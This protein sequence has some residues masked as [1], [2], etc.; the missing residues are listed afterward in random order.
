MGLTLSCERRPVFYFIGDSITEHGS[1]SS[2]SGFITILQNHYV[3]SVDCVNRGLSGYNS[4]WVLEH[5]MPIYAK[6]LQSEYS[7]AFVTVFLGANDAVLEHGPDKAQRSYTRNASA[8]KYAKVCVELAAAENVHVLDLH[9]YFNTT[10][11][12]VNVR[13]TYFV[14]GLHFSEKGNKEVGKLL[15][16][17]IN[18]M[19]DK[20][21]LDRFNKW[22]LPDWHD[23]VPHQ[24]DT[25]E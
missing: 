23:L 7:A 19:F 14:D 24:D 12:D 13:K 6:E 2:K 20:E 5:G 18:G 1:D 4:K 8:A 17:A 25:Q 21:E 22:Q 15:G 11:P 10:F 9:T 16:V 3:R